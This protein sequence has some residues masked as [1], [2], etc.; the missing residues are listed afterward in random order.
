M[1]QR[2]LNAELPR[3][4]AVLAVEEMPA[5]FHPIRDVLRKRYRYVIH[6]GPVRDV[7]RRH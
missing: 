6:D 3:D 4:M 7:F 5:G 1:L 2:A